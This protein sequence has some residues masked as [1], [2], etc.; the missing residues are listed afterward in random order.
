MVRPRGETR[1]D[2]G[3]MTE[4]GMKDS[5]ACCLTRTNL[6]N[7]RPSEAPV[8]KGQTVSDSIRRLEQASLESQK[9]DGWLPRGEVGGR[10]QD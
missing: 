8:T 2:E 5:Q 3:T 1:P 6:R 9:P 7:V 10:M 4:T